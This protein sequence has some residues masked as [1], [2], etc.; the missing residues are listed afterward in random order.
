MNVLFGFLAEFSNS[1]NICKIM[2][3]KIL[4]EE[5]ILKKSNLKNQFWVDYWL[6]S[7]VSGFFG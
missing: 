2:L 7:L 5:L 6:F 4:L 1:F 3:P